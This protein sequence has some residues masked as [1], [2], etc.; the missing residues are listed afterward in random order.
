LRREAGNG[1]HREASAFRAAIRNH[2]EA[3]AGKKKAIAVLSEAGLDRAWEL[4][5]QNP[6]VG[7][8]YE[9][10]T[11]RDIVS[12]L[13]RYGSISVNQGEFVRRLLVKIDSRAEI[14]AARAAEN[15][16]AAPCPTGRVKVTG[17]VL[18]Q[19]CRKASTARR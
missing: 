4:Y 17:S 16:A 9:E 7:F 19:S 2:L 14:A 13:V 15:E 11:I 3:Q 10:T 18:A 12:K 1:R 6:R 5:A 8:A